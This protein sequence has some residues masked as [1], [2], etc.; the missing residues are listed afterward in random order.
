LLTAKTREPKGDGWMTRAQFCETLGISEGTG[1]LYLRRGVASG[2]LEKFCGTA[3]H[4]NQANH[5]TW[6][7]PIVQKKDKT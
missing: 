7:R 4:P 6:Y 3:N 1:Q 2:H 5:Q